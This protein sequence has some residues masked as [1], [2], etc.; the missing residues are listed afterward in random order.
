MRTRRPTAAPTRAARRRWVK[1]AVAIT[2]IVVVIGGAIG[3]DVL[4]RSAGEAAEQRTNADFYSVPSPLPHGEPGSVI[5]SERIEGAPL[6]TTAWRVLYH[7]RDLNDGDIPVS[8]VI[9]VPDGPAPQDGRTVVAWG[10]PTTGAAAHCA[11]SLAMDPFQLIEGMHLF[12]DA[13][14]AVVATDYPGLGVEGDSSYLLGVPESNGVLDSVRAARQIEDVHAGAR[15][16][17]WGH[18]QGGQAALFAAQRART[19]APDLH[20]VGVAVAAPAADLRDL[21]TAN[22]TQLAGVTLTSYAVPAYEK[23]Y[24][25]R[26][27]ASQIDGILTERGAEVTPTLSSLCLLTQA[28]R[29]HA[30]A[31]P[32][33]GSYVTSDPS[34]TEPWKTM[35]AENSAGGAPIDVPIFVGQ[36]LADELVS[37]HA[38]ERF[39]TKLC[40]AD[41]SVDFHRFDGTDHAW[42]AYASL[43]A[44]TAW[45]G[46]LEAG[47]SPSTC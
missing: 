40:D 32:L 37:P 47:R 45:L 2:L 9:I 13:G 42:A 6:D 36:G 11:P 35:L 34:T 27:P 30:L 25:E 28:D 31:T 22:L 17:L 24:A 14:Y 46:E 23:A 4:R 3:A 43:P 29:I 26:Y 15:V 33:I 21:L 16:V 39:V 38:T 44:L 10:H 8:A 18:S 12:L 19:Y 7:S 20:V 41:E 1:Y 5:R